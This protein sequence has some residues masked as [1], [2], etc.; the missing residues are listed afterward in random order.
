LT[1]VEHLFAGLGVSDYDAGLAWYTRLFGREPDVTVSET[2]AMWQLVGSGWVYVI[3]D[4]ERAGRGLLTLLVDDLDASVANLAER[5][6]VAG[7]IET[8][9][10]LYRKAVV[11]DA[12]GN[13]I[14]LGEDLSDASSR[15]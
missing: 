3:R 9:P 4:G 2:E 11:N 13:T 15:A 5:G 1:G 14:S 6:I 12:D 8:E 10:G 7:A